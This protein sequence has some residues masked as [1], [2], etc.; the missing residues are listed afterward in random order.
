MREQKSLTTFVGT[1]VPTN[2]VGTTVIASVV[3]TRIVGTAVPASV[4][5]ITAIGRVLPATIIVLTAYYWKSCVQPDLEKVVKC[6]QA[7][8]SEF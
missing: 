5:G 7:E 3:P 4:V 1:V 8:N 2:V 6:P